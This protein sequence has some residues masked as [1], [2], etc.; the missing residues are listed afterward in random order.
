MERS[1]GERTQNQMD[2]VD[3]G[4]VVINGDGAFGAK[5]FYV[6]CNTFG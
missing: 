1:E 6:G 2:G 5:V 4:A 3:Q